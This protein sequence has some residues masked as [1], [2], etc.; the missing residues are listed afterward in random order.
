MEPLTEK[1]DLIIVFEILEVTGVCD[2]SICQWQN[3]SLRI[4]INNSTR[5]QVD[6]IMFIRK[7]TLLIPF[8]LL[9]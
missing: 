9:D 4:L 1:N 8:L 2:Y 6:F 5:S 7:P 3:F